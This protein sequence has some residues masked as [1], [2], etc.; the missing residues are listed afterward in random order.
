M[1]R[2]RRTIG[3]ALAISLLAAGCSRSV[4]GDAG[5]AVAF[6]VSPTATPSGLPTAGA[7]APAATGQPSVSA[8]LVP[9]SVPSSSTTAATVGPSASG[10]APPASSAVVSSGPPVKWV[11]PEPKDTKRQNN[12]YGNRI[13][14]VGESYQLT[15]T[16]TKERALLFIVDSIKLD[17]ACDKTDVKP[18]NGHFLVI[19]LRV[20]L[21]NV[22]GDELNQGS[23]GFTASDWTAFD[24]KNVAQVGTD[25]FDNN[26]LSTSLIPFASDMD[27]G[28][29]YK[30]KVALDVSATKGTV[31]LMSGV[32]GGW[33]YNYG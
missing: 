29:T 25:S 9:T 27:S 2:I 20:Q 19:T 33:V 7:S 28:E 5:P 15:Y 30:G 23:I 26:C 4:A 10:A 6:G 12:S 22:T 24:S 8:P 14:A 18:A 16:Q 21:G 17:G 11:L 1:I 3:V 32:S 31:V 13:A